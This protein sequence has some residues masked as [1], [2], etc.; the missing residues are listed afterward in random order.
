LVPEIWQSLGVT[1]LLQVRESKIQ[2]KA[3]VSGRRR[4]RALIGID[5]LRVTMRPAVHDTQIAERAN[6]I[7]VGL[8]DRLKTSF[9]RSVIARRES[10]NRAVENDL[11]RIGRRQEKK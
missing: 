6:M 11:R 1:L 9:G 8:Q 10:R 5:C 4:P 3:R 2:P 7:R